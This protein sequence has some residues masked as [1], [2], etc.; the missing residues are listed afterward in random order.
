MARGLVFL[1]ELSIKHEFFKKFTDMG[2]ELVV[3]A[4]V[5]KKLSNHRIIFK[6]IREGI[7]FLAEHHA[8]ELVIPIDELNIDIVVYD[9]RNVFVPRTDLPEFRPG[10]YLLYFN[11]SRTIN[12]LI[13]KENASGALCKVFRDS[14][15]P[16][17]NIKVKRINLMNGGST[18]RH[19]PVP[20]SP[21]NAVTAESN[22]DPYEP[23]LVKQSSAE[24]LF[25]KTS[26]EYAGALALVRLELRKISEVQNYEPHITL[27]NFKDNSFFIQ[28]KVLEKNRKYG[29]LSIGSGDDSVKFVL[30]DKIVLNGLECSQFV[31]DR[32][33]AITELQQLKISL[34]EKSG[35]EP[36]MLVENL[37]KPLIRDF[38]RVQVDEYFYTVENFVYI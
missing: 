23:V 30:K 4:S 38:I 34:F 17:K 36:V 3:P 28:F 1:A 12:E 13:T 27:L 22:I 15:I 29:E 20:D 7:V 24:Q 18:V 25:I 33:V 6:K 14:I 2:L 19:L 16:D 8:D 26:E 11:S 21:E 10:K 5:Q 37:P 9:K 31:S 32:P 35:K